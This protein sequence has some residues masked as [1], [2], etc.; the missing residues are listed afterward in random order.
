MQEFQKLTDK[1]KGVSG[2][3]VWGRNLQ[4]DVGYGASK[5]ARPS[6]DVDG[7]SDEVVIYN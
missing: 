3:V 1:V 4:V 7:L 5:E 2:P 6:R